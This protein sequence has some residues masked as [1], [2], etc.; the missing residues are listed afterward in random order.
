MLWDFQKPFVIELFNFYL[1]SSFYYTIVRELAMCWLGWEGGIA[2]Q[3][4][5]ILNNNSH[6]FHIF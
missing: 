6:E 3:K 5:H 1:F 4:E 2:I